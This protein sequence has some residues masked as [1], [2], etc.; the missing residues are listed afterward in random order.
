MHTMYTHVCGFF[1]PK[2]VVQQ[3]EAQPCLLQFCHGGR[4]AQAELELLIELTA[5]AKDF[6]QVYKDARRHGCIELIRDTNAS[7]GITRRLKE[8]TGISKESL[9]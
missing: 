3:G 7:R 6:D 2:H 8:L 4:F 9:N 5:G 1:W